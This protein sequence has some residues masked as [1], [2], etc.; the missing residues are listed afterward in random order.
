MA[1]F[2]FQISPPGCLRWCLKNLS[3]HTCCATAVCMYFSTSQLQQLQKRRWLLVNPG[4][5]C[6]IAASTDGG[7]VMGSAIVRD[8]GC[9]VQCAARAASVGFC[10]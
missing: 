6:L 2:N 4:Q 8:P 7:G 1:F 3:I 9:C 10:G 5:Q